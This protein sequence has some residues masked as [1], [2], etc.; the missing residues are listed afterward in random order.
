MNH[1]SLS[2]LAAFVAVAEHRSFR[3]AADASGVSR[4]ALSHALLE[5]EQNLGVRLFNRTTRSV[6]P[7]A[8]GQRLL[9]DIKPVLRALDT[10]LDTLAQAR[11]APAGTLRIHAYKSAVRLLLR[12]VVPTFLSS[13]PDVELDLVTDGRLIDIVAAGFDAGVRLAED[14]PQDMIAVPFGGAVRFVAVASPAYLARQGTPATPD[15]LRRHRCIRHR[16][17]SGRLYRWEFSKRGREVAV[18][19]PGALTL[20][21]NGLMTQAAAD[22]LGVAYVP[23]SFARDRLEAR[24]LVAVL[25]DWCPPVPGLTLYYP[26][27]R[28]V[29]SA[30]RAFIDVLKEVDQR[31]SPARP[32]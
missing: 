22:G 4:S 31:R 29:P 10:A 14:V 6:A 24:T 7:T 3:K 12:E 1:P 25:A 11:G 30:L 19:V 18:D 28:H 17:P 27:N 16:V 5:L 9:A 15:D 13:Y 21:D 26:G 8:A 2:E 20:D 23:E 32:R